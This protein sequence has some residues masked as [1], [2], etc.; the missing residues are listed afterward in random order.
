MSNEEMDQIA[1]GG[2]WNG[3]IRNASSSTAQ[4]T[5]DWDL[6]LETAAERGRRRRGTPTT[7]RQG[8]TRRRA[9]SW[10]PPPSGTL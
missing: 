2:N 1:S 9:T 4:F 10:F 3:G 6:D 5:W 7:A 8:E